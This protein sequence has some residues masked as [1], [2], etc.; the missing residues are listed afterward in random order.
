MVG[1]SREDGIDKHPCN[2]REIRSRDRMKFE[3]AK[4]DQRQPT[5]VF[6][7]FQET[8]KAEKVHENSSDNVIRENRLQAPNQIVP[9]AGTALPAH[10]LRAE[11]LVCKSLCGV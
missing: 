4:N 11:T 3:D 2:R 1:E 8:Q 7:P 5:P 9:N 10:D 6:A